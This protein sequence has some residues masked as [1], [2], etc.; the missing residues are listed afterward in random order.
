MGF[1]PVPCDL[2]WTGAALTA[3]RLVI[4]IANK[5]LGF[6]HHFIYGL[7]F[8]SHLAV[9]HDNTT[10]TTHAVC[11]GMDELKIRVLL[12]Y[13]SAAKGLAF[14]PYLIPFVTTEIALTDLER[15]S[16]R[17]YQDFLP[18]RETMGCNLYFHSYQ[19]HQSSEASASTYKTPDLTEMPRKLTALLNA[20]ASNTTSVSAH[21]LVV[22]C[23][24]EQIQRYNCMNRTDA[25]SILYVR[26][27]DRL[28]LMRQVIKNTRRRNDYVKESVQ[29]HVQMVKFSTFLFCLAND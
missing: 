19:M 7:P 28:D 25:E 21:A 1:D 22:E 26:M 12:D 23:L 20:L 8:I 16:D 18:V 13:L 14:Q 15:F 4:S 17:T 5:Y 11:Y 3:A 29:A 9:T 24:D 6:M 27:R 10:R 2:A